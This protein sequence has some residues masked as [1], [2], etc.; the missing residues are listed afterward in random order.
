MRIAL[1]FAEFQ[2]AVLKGYK[3]VFNMRGF[4]S[5][6]YSG[7]LKALNSETHGS[8]FCMDDEN[9]RRL[10]RME[11]IYKKEYVSVTTYNGKIIK[12]VQVYVSPEVIGTEKN[13]NNNEKSL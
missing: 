6:T 10:D 5:E 12:N 8:V 4:G 2:P 11:G 7:V 3:M 1:I 13:L 9:K